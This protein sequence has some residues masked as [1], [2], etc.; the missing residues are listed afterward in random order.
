MKKTIQLTI[1]FAITLIATAV[2]ANPPCPERGNSLED[3]AYCTTPLPNKM[4]RVL[5]RASYN[6]VQ[7][8]D[9]HNRALMASMSGPAAMPQVDPVVPAT[10]F[11]SNLSPG[12]YYPYFRYGISIQIPIFP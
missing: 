4:G 2:L 5:G 12:F 1:T 11:A 6:N 3:F 10:S 8:M 7:P 9:H